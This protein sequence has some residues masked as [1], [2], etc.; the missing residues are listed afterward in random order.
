MIKLGVFLAPN[1]KIKKVIINFKKKVKKNFGTQNYLNHPPHCTLCV[2]YASNLFLQ[3]F[4]KKN[5]IVKY[6]KEFKLEITDVF[7][8]DP[9]TK[10][11]TLIF[12]IKKNKFLSSVQLQILKFMKQYLIN[13]KINFPNLKMQ[14]NFKKYGYP[15]VNSNWLP[16]FTIAS[17]AKKNNQEAFINNFKNYKNNTPK[18]KVKYIYFYEIKK[19]QHKF[20]WKTKLV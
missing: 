10:G 19:Q 2:L 5:L 6:K 7:F 3:N 16:H 11:N 18:Q 4:K 15:F 14:N 12:K 9:I 8:N 20:L 17:I 1:S 13:K